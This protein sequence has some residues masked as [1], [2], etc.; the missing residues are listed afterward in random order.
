[1]E[2]PHSYD[3]SP[4][5]YK[6]ETPVSQQERWWNTT[7]VC[8]W[9]SGGVED[10]VYVHCTGQLASNSQKGG[11]YYVQLTLVHFNEV[12]DELSNSGSKTS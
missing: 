11:S 1:M 4:V 7:S 12:G 6:G 8:R 2:H 3:P 5:L 9:D 10:I